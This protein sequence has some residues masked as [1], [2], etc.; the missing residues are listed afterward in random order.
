MYLPP[1]ASLNK[2]T[3]KKEVGPQSSDN[4]NLTISGGSFLVCMRIGFIDGKRKQS[5][6]QFLKILE[7][8]KT[9]EKDQFVT[10]IVHNQKQVQS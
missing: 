1:P 3:K 7:R 4:Q 8:W 5:R 2:P 9:L 6:N 10:L